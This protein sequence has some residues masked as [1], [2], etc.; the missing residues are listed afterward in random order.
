MSTCDERSA[1]IVMRDG[2]AAVEAAAH[3]S[4]T[5]LRTSADVAPAAALGVEGGDPRL[6]L[7]QSD[8]SRRQLPSNNSAIFEISGTGG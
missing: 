2:A 7:R 6:G 1:A 8:E 5:T 4:L 3:V